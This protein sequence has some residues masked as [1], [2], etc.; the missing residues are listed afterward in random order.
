[1]VLHKRHAE[2]KRPLS[3]SP[4][5]RT[6]SRRTSRAIT[7]VLYAEPAGRVRPTTGR[8]EDRG[9]RQSGPLSPS[10]PSAF[11]RTH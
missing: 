6:L 10:L 3:D 4:F 1:V 7:V 9:A 8:L 2:K 5:D 11:T